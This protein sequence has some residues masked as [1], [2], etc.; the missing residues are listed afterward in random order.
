[1]ARQTITPQHSTKSNYDNVN[2]D[3]GLRADIMRCQMESKNT[4]TQ[5]GSIYVGVGRADSNGI[6]YTKELRSGSQYQCLNV[7]DANGNIGYSHLNMHHFDGQLTVGNDDEVLTVTNFGTLRIEQ[8]GMFVIN[9][10]FLTILSDTNSYERIKFYHTYNNQLYGFGLGVI[11]NGGRTEPGLHICSTE[12]GRG[13][14]IYSNSVEIDAEVNMTDYDLHG[15]LIYATAFIQTSDRRLKE[16]ITSFSSKKS[17]LDLPLYKYDFINGEKNSIGCMAQDLQKIC[18]EIVHENKDGYLGIE[19]NK[20]V[21]LLLEEV[22]KLR[23]EV[24]ELKK[25]H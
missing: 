21:F 23:K 6:A 17:I 25:E 22:K 10:G 1:M 14:T 16:N 24:D 11:V 20:I 12:T 4:L 8:T 15:D 13:V 9:K 2:I 5:N 3:S 19:E 7:I 18:P